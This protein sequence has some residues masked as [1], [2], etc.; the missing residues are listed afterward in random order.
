M[1]F[2]AGMVKDP[3]ENVR[4]RGVE[5]IIEARNH[6]EIAKAKSIEQA[7]RDLKNSSMIMNK[8]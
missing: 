5:R 7:K 3:D 4:R 8:M 2:F 6:P 1:Y